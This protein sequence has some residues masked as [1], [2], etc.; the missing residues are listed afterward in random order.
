MIMLASFA[1]PAQINTQAVMGTPYQDRKPAVAGSFYPS[2]PAELR[3]AVNGYLK[4][5]VQDQTDGLVRALVVP[6]AG[7]VFSA[8]VA[9]SGYNQINSD[10]PYK[11]IFIL[12]SSHRMSLGKASVY[13]RGNYVTPLGTLTVDTETGKKLAGNTKYFTDDPSAHL[14]EHSIEVQLPFLQV[15][16]DRQIPIVPIVVG[17]QVPDICGGIAEALKPYFTPDNLF[18]I[19]ADFS[20]YPAYEDAVKV[21]AATAEAFCKNSPETFLQVL[22]T[23]EQKRIPDLATSMCAWP[24]GLILLKLTEKNPSLLFSRTDYKNSGDIKP[25]GDKSQVVGYHA[26]T[27]S[28]VQQGQF[29][30]TESDKRE[31]IRIA[32][33]TLDSYIRDHKLPALTPEAYSSSLKTKAG[34]FVTLKIDG[35]LRGCIGT[36]EPSVSLYQVIQQ[37]TVASSTQDN[38]FTPVQARELEKIHIEISVLTPMKKIRDIKEIRLGTDGIYI[39]KGYQ[40]GTFLPQVATE[41]GWTL[42]EFLG[43][44]ARDKAGLGWTGWKDADI[45]TYQA[46]IIEE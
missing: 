2:D 4:G 7:Y 42:E 24:S 26:I 41:T 14:Q 12:A 6:H 38:R 28:E 25:Y 20:H 22:K 44:C 36:F 33:A 10:H 17:T 13:T 35:S 19:S 11:R 15:K 27:I 8:G 23:N 31:L 9:A 30:L 34:A 40:G 16:F 5:G 1:S 32:R 21:D 39:K 37:M 18:I 45:Y 29:T 43:H 46:I 3:K